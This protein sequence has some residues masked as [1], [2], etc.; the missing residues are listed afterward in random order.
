MKRP[1]G[2]MPRPADREPRPRLTPVVILD[3]S[4]ATQPSDR[5][6]G[7]ADAL[8]RMGHYFADMGHYM[9][10]YFGQMGHEMGHYSA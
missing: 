9:G 10:H 8:A 2:I 4:A 1:P 5:P 6:F 3:G 7:A